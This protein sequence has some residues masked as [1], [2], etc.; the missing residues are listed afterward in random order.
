[1]ILRYGKEFIMAVEY[2]NTPLN[3]EFWDV[4]SD[5]REEENFQACGYVD[6]YYIMESGWFV[7]IINILDECFVEARYSIWEN[8]NQELR[9]LLD[10]FNCL[11]YDESVTL[12]CLCDYMSV[13]V[14]FTYSKNCKTYFATS[15][16]CNSELHDKFSDNYTSKTLQKI[17]MKCYH[18]QEEEK[19]TRRNQG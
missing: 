3:E 10:D 4:Y 18:E 17:M 16:Q 7:L 6:D 15:V 19:K 5:V 13:D 11:R 9:K 12:K 14:G 1:M 2:K 8:Q